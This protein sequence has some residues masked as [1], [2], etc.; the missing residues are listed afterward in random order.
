M[1][2]ITR[3]R[4]SSKSKQAIPPANKQM[5]P[6]SVKQPEPAPAKAKPLVC[7]CGAVEGDADVKKC[8]KC[9]W[10]WCDMCM[11]AAVACPQCGAE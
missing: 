1:A 4:K 9:G 5:V 11:R 2:R 8:R 7:G 3:K 6:E 10:T